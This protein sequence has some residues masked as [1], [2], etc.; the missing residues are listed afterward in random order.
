MKS[1]LL[2]VPF[3]GLLLTGAILSAQAQK[4]TEL[5]EVGIYAPQLTK[6]DGRNNEW[7]NATFAQNKATSISYLISNDDKNL[8]LVVKSTDVGN[9]TKIMAGGI[10]FSVNPDGKK[11]DKESITLTYPLINRAQFR[12]GGQGGGGGAIVRPAFGGMG[13]GGVQLTSKQR[14]SAMAAMQKTQLAQVKEIKI[15]GFKK[16]TDTLLSIYNDRGIKAAASIDK[17]N[18]FFYEAAIPLEELG[19]TLDNAKEFAYNVKLNGLQLPGMDFNRGGGGGEGGG[20]FA[21]GGGGPRGGGGGPR[22]SGIDFQALI[23]PTDFWGKY[24]LT[25]K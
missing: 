15:K 9:N 12:R 10:T 13:P 23:S 24:T 5:Q 4:V 20:G 18:V 1:N 14:D 22:G 17:D 2:I 19:L 3:I 16:T 6:A 21:G 8:Y 25:K 11:K 7:A